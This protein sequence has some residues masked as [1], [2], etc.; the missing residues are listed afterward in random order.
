MGA[1]TVVDGFADWLF[2]TKR[3]HEI[4]LSHSGAQKDFVDQLCVDLE[5]A[6]R[7]PFFDRRS[8][9]KGEEFGQQLLTAAQECAVAVVVVS[10]EYF[11]RSKWPMLELTAIVQAPSRPRILPLFLL[12]CKEFKKPKRRQRWFAL[13]EEWA[14]ADPRVRP[15]AWKEAL[16]VLEGRTGMEF[17]RQTGEVAYR[18]D[19][20]T[21]VCSMVLQD[22]VSYAPSDDH[23]SATID[24][25]MHADPMHVN[26]SD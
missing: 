15:S 1:I 7:T 26:V 16:R 19:I 17:V 25:N 5:R 6:K 2:V 9:S 18:K 14:K 20:V 21:A 11:S 22:E 8:L 4:F 12:S 13:W 24:L 3:S 10:E 23:F